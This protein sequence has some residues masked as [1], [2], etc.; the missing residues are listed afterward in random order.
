MKNIIYSIK[1]L[2]Y[3]YRTKKKLA[4][5]RSIAKLAD[6]IVLKPYF[7][8]NL[9]KDSLE[10]GKNTSLDGQLVTKESGKISIG[11]HCSFRRNTFIGALNSISIGDHVF[12]AEHIFIC[13]NN[14]HPTSPTLRKEMT[15]SPT[16]TSPW[17]WHSETVDS[18][19]III[20]DTVWIG[21]YATI[22]KGVTIGR[23]SIVAAGAVVT[24][25]FPAFSVIAGNP[26]KLVKTLKNDL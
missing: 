24:K 18:A 16:N 6:P 8:F 11:K 12:G 1:S 23:G 4:Y 19:P 25:S 26:A 7:G 20:E 17:K 14:N 9:M 10:V 3:S 21:R 22:L 13:D 5:L 2:Y 15:M